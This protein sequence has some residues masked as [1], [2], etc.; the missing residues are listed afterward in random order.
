MVAH[1]SAPSPFASIM[2]RELFSGAGQA[3]I[4]GNGVKSGRRD[5]NGNLPRGPLRG[6]KMRDVRRS[7][8]EFPADL[9][10]Y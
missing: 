9:R 2:E 6:S 7:R 10:L 5:I 1:V 4:A 8:A 3:L